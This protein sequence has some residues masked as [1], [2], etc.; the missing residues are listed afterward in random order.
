MVDWRGSSLQIVVALIGSSLI[1]T[2]LTSLSTFFS[3]PSLDISAEVDYPSSDTN[4]TYRIFLVNNGYSAAKDVRFTM[5][6][7]DAKVINAAMIYQNEN[8]TLTK[9]IDSV[10]AFSSRLSP[11]VK[12]GIVNNITGTP[13]FS[14]RFKV[15]RLRDFDTD[16]SN[17]Y[18]HHTQPFT[19]TVTHDEGGNTYRPN[20]FK[21]SADPV[22][23][24]FNVDAL[25]FFIPIVVGIL[26][27]GIAHR[28]KRKSL[29]KYASN[30]L[31]DIEAAKKHFKEANS[32]SIVSFKNYDF[33]IGN[34]LEVFDNYE[35]YKL[36]N[37]FYKGLKERELKILDPTLS[38]N[39]DDVVK[40]Q[41]SKCYTQATRAYDKIVWKK[42]Y[43]LDLILLLPSVI[44]GSYFVTLVCEGVTTILFIQFHFI[45]S[46]YF[47]AALLILF[48]ARTIGT[49]FI[50]R[51]ILQTVQG[52]N[53][54]I[55]LFPWLSR[56]RTFLILSAVI[57]GF[58]SLYMI[59]ISVYSFQQ[60][61]DPA[62][63]DYGL[64]RQIIEDN[65]TM[66][67]LLID[68]GRMLLLTLLVSQY[69]RTRKINGQDRQNDKEL[70][71]KV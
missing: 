31:K 63:F 53:M 58:P 9:T 55:H 6:Y 57:M 2:A 51:L 22:K 37:D 71:K 13:Y 27:V 38:S 54:I 32:K 10:V 47:T 11:G 33:N 59:T 50:M 7:P 21:E 14:E 48:I 65:S 35:Y 8:F 29:S 40:E 56:K 18:Y 41:N 15:D 62:Q 68:I 49:F 60:V 36:I 45:D 1:L 34:E 52:R 4:T 19:I 20:I 12:I 5:T 17:N 42:F 28:H 67:V 30:V 43:K 3:K 69:P 64:Q 24:Y 46:E 25:K 23:V 61:P 70:W 39:L 26:L 16:N 44:L 66:I